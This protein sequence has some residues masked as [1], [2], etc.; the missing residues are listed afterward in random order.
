[1][2]AKLVVVSRQ[3]G[4]FGRSVQSFD[5]T[6]GPRV[7]WLCQPVLDSA[8]HCPRTNGGQIRACANHVEPHWPGIGGVPVPRLLC[9]LNAIVCQ[10]AVN[11]IGHGFEMVFEEFPRRFATG[12]PYQLCHRE[13]AGSIDSDKEMEFSLLRSEL[14]DINVEEANWVALEF[15]PV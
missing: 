4:F 12:L 3:G 1:M 8:H 7:V 9:E 5:L 11:A 6:V 10:D 2:P 13:L 14:S 15:L